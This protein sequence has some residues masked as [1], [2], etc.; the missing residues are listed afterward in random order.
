[1]AGTDIEIG[2]QLAR[3][4]GSV[5]RTI[6]AFYDGS[7][8]S[9][10]ASSSASSSTS[11]SAPSSSSTPSS[12]SAPSASVAGSAISA[13]LVAAAAPAPAPALLQPPQQQHVVVDVL[14]DDDDDDDVL[15]DDGGGG[16]DNSGGGR[17]GACFLAPQPKRVRTSAPGRPAASTCAH[18]N[19]PECA[20]CNPPEPAAGAG[21][22]AQSWPR[23]LG[24]LQLACY[25]TTKGRG[26]LR[27]GD[28][29]LLEGEGEEAGGGRGKRGKAKEAIV[30]VVKRDGEGANRSS[31]LGRL[32]RDASVFLRPLLPPSAGGEGGGAG[33]GRA[34]AAVAGV[35]GLRCVVAECAEELSICSPIWLRAEVWATE[36]FFQVRRASSLVSRA[37][38]LVSRAS[39]LV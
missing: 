24:T 4:G 21:G 9:S 19:G 11:S 23:L 15:D 1:M 31:Q 29:V 26:L 27:R 30:R 18:G 3:S 8:S 37:S 33:A 17:G 14:D 20:Q 13:V 22:P 25:S 36:A 28:S 2:I 32:P 16:G 5:E 7:S 38:S 12:S 34:A 6:N 35:V 39:S 10:S